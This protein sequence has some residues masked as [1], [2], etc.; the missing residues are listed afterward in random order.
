[1]VGRARQV[2][3]D[4]PAVA[5]KLIVRHLLHLVVQF[6]QLVHQVAAAG[7]LNAHAAPAFLFNGAQAA[8]GQRRAGGKRSPHI[9][10]A[11]GS[12]GCLCLHISQKDRLLSRDSG[13]F[14]LN[15]SM[16]RCFDR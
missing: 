1:M 10:A 7:V 12:L 16:R 8:L 5:A 11:F 15:Q 13:A 6:T 14:A 2:R 3:T 4:L 9:A